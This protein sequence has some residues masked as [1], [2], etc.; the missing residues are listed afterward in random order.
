MHAQTKT[1]HNTIGGSES[2]DHR[3]E[4]I[5]KTLNTHRYFPEGSTVEE[6]TD[7]N[8][9][10]CRYGSDDKPCARGFKGKSIKPSFH[11]SFR[12]IEKREQFIS[13][14]LDQ[15]RKNHAA[16]VTAKAARKALQS[17]P[18][19]LKA[20]DVLVN[21]WGWEQ[22]NVDFFQVIESKG[23][24]VKIR[25]ITSQST[26]ECGGSSMSDHVVAVRDSFRK[27]Q[28]DRYEDV[29]YLVKRVTYGNTVSMRFGC[30][31]LWDGSPHYRSWYA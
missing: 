17:Q 28:N 16:C 9:V 13:A 31:S 5:M 7:I 23:H 6:F 21:V 20:G 12:S 8:I 19:T 10:V 22:T 26:G 27:T 4:T 29:D 18:N 14:W 1:D 30:C 25:S 11:Y 3:F 15:Q 24:T 2:R